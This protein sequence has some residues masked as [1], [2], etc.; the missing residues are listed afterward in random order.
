MITVMMITK[1]VD[2]LL[3]FLITVFNYVQF[4]SMHADL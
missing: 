2:S 3:L 4:I 1:M